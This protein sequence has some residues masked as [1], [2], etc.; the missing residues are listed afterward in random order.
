MV[1]FEDG[2][3]FFRFMANSSMISIRAS[4]TCFPMLLLAA[5]CGSPTAPAPMTVA[6]DTCFS[7]QRWIG[8]AGMC[9]LPALPD[10]CGCADDGNPCSIELCVLGA[11]V[12]RA[13]FDGNSC[14]AGECHA[15]ACCTGCWDGAACQTGNDVAACGSHGIAC[16]MCP[17]DTCDVATCTGGCAVEP[18]NGPSCPHCGSLDERCCAG[19]TCDASLTCTF[20]VLGED[21]GEYR[22][23]AP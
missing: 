3:K 12:H 4:A 11:C 22:C 16:A 10:A 17:S 8:D 7:G 2:L 1:A 14:G 9:V 21:L 5:A 15:G 20:V 6:D 19:M 13:D 18:I 23:T